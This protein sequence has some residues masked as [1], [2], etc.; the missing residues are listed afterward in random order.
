M[1][2]DHLQARVTGVRDAGRTVDTDRGPVGN[3]GLILANGGRFLRRIPGID[4]VVTLCQGGRS[5]QEIGRRLAELD[6]GRIALGFAGNPQ[7]RA[8]M[9]G[10]PMF[11]LAFCLDN[12]LRR[13][14]RRARFELTFFSPN[15]RP[16]QRLGDRAVAGLM[17]R[18]DRQDIRTHL[19][20]RIQRFEPGRV[21]TDGG[22]VESDLTVFMPGMTGPDWLADSDLPVTE[23]GHIEVDERA[24]VPG[25]AH[26][27]AVGDC[28]AFPGP[29]WQAKQAHA[30]DVQASVAAR[31]LSAELRGRAADRS[32][33]HEIVCILDSLRDGVLVV[34]TDRRQVVLPPLRLAHWGKIALEKL[35]L[36]KYGPRQVRW[37]LLTGRSAYGG[38][39]DTAPAA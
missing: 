8:A 2:A 7:H 27:W 25:L 28:A 9:R 21:V 32:V 11:E 16:G 3:D 20:H 13:E 36:W 33:R 38:G 30:A 6:G 24:R 35:F 22:G 12:Q 5:A 39:G 23:S 31:N 10:G 15:P 29:S 1:D 4:N 34:R 19:G 17:R 18:L 14:G 26:V 37:R